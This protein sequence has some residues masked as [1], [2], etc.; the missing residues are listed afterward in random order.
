MKY[1]I[2]IVDDERKILD[3]IKKLGHWQELSI[4]IVDEC[5]NG[6]TALKSILLHQPDIVLSDIKM[7]GYD[8]IQLIEKV[9]EHNLD[10][11]FILLSG[12]RHFEYARSAI[13]LNVVDYLL[14]PIDEQQLNE[15]LE[16]VCKKIEQQRKQVKL[17]VYEEEQRKEQ[18]RPLWELVLSEKADLR[19][20]FLDSE[21]SCNEQFGTIFKAGCYQ[22]V[23]TVT[24]LNAMLEHSDSLYS[25]K[26]EHFVQKIFKDMAT[27]YWYSTYMGNI[28]ILN[29]AEERREEIKSGLS[30]LFCGIRD[31][32]EIYGEFRLNFGV[33]QVKTKVSELGVAMGEAG[34]A[35]WGRLNFIGNSI[36]EY[37]QV[38]HLHRFQPE[39]FCSREELAEVQSCL[40]YLKRERLGE[41]FGEF[42]RKAGLLN[43]ACSVDMRKSFIAMTETIRETLNEHKE[44]E[45]IVKQCYY[46]YL[47]S[48]SFQQVFKNLYGIL[49][50]Y[51]YDVEKRVQEKLG[52]P[53]SVAIRYMKE[54]YA[55]G[56]SMEETAQVAGISV[57]Y[58][59]KLF[60]REMGVSF[61]EYLTQIRLDKSKELL[62]RTNMTIKEIALHVGYP[63]EK[64]YSKLFKKVTGI[65]PTDYRRLY[66]N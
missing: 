10:T 14:K 20:T 3:L 38:E 7:P 27:V 62:E 44:Q 65:K 6:E 48:R 42:Y 41:V 46:S 58:L 26:F 43:N 60:K 32:K 16:K 47:E 23:C 66:G 59:S 37:S 57:G 4:E 64:Y 19:G 49:E 5:N 1:K 9:R 29:Y 24:N 61:N 54:H 28:I 51:L 21:R 30:V 34:A 45:R 13:Q 52:Q 56:I 33:S 22:V 11:F 35:E 2:L 31:L 18:L 15:T 53:I 40:R 50:H 55:K 12:Y 25:H 63:D 39:E 17:A 8:G 36:I